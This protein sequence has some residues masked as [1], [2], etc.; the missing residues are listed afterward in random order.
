MLDGGSQAV[1]PRVK[2]EVISEREQQKMNQTKLSNL[3]ATPLPYPLGNPL[4]PA[5]LCE[6]MD[7]AQGT[8]LNMGQKELLA[9]PQPLQLATVAATTTDESTPDGGFS[10]GTLI[11]AAT[12]G[13]I[14]IAG[15]VATAVS[16]K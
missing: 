2:A 11:A 4:T 5:I 7:K 8:K 16:K 14:A 3:Q 6:A 10:T 13:G 1:K 15:A 9:A 12:V